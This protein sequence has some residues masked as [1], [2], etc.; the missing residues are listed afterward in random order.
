MGNFTYIEEKVFLNRPTLPKYPIPRVAIPNKHGV[1]KPN[2]QQIIVGVIAAGIGILCWHIVFLLL[3]GLAVA[4]ICAALYFTG[5]SKYD[6][7]ESEYQSA[8][9]KANNHNKKA[10]SEKKAWDDAWNNWNKNVLKTAYLA[11]TNDIFGRF[12]RALSSSVRLTIKE[13]YEDRK[14]ELKERKEKEYSEQQLSEQ[15]ERKKAEFK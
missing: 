2:I 11:S 15:L 6:N 9:Y 14:A 13:L 5:K 12:V 10:D 7:A 4:G 8:L 1:T 3:V